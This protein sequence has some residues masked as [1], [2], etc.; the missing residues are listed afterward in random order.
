V[1]HRFNLRGDRGAVDCE[2]KEVEPHKTLSYA[3]A[4]RGLAPHRAAFS[5]K[6]S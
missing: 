4:A 6:K 5:W 3:W 2:V 1:D